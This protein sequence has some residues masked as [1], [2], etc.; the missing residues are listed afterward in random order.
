MVRPSIMRITSTREAQQHQP[1][2]KMTQPQNKAQ[3][4]WQQQ[5]LGLGSAPGAS[6]GPGAT[7]CEGA[8]PITWPGSC[9]RCM[10]R[11]R[12]SCAARA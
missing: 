1:H 11:T 6:A 7:A 12:P 5:Q 8:H 10:A 2:N 9:W 4:R 3:Q